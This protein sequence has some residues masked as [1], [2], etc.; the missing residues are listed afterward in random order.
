V[1]LSIGIGWLGVGPL[2]GNRDA[3]IGRLVSRKASEPAPT[4]PV[5]YR[6]LDRPYGGPTVESLERAAPPVDLHYRPTEEK[7]F[8]AALLITGFEPDGSLVGADAIAARLYDGRSCTGG[9]VEIDLG[10]DT[11]FRL[12]PLPVPTGH[13]VD[14]ASV[15]FDGVP[16]P[17][18]E[19]ESGQPAVQFERHRVGRVKY[20]T[21]PGA[22]DQRRVGSGWPELPTE[23]QRLAR[24]VEDLPRA[25]RALVV[26]DW[27]ARRVVYD[28]SSTTAARYREESTTSQGIF[29]RS[30]SIGAGDCDV[31][32]SLVAAT[33]DSSG[34]PARLAIGWMG[35][36]GRLQPD[37]HAWVEFLGEDGVWRVV[38]ASIRA[39]QE[40]RRQGGS[41]VSERPA[42]AS[43]ENWGWTPAI[44]AALLFLAGLAVLLGG[45]TWERR[46][47]VGPKND[48]PGLLR[49][50]ATRP[51]AFARIRPVFTR[52]VVPL[53]G[54]P[55][56]S[57]ARARKES[58]RGRLCRG[59]AGTRLAEQASTGG[60][61]VIDA[62]QAAG[63]AVADVLGAIDLDRW[64]EV[65]DSSWS[66]DVTA[67]VEAALG[68]GG[69]PCR[70]RVANGLG[71]ETMVL[72]G[73]LLG[74]GTDDCLAI[75]NAEGDL[76]RT[77]R[78]L[79]RQR[80]PARAVLWLADSMVHRIGVPYEALGRCLASL[81]AAAV[82][83]RAWRAS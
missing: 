73:G 33:L 35:A 58:L 8:I 44:V 56:T 13:R 80:E 11:E 55:P 52:R 7:P 77:V 78:S 62:E 26:A 42:P 4:A 32:N 60:G 18:V 22:S 63:R 24:E 40:D 30:L 75:V 45:R 83:E 29:H 76:W 51:G 48:L 46:L 50:A 39:D 16:I 82:K 49:G 72:D 54:R 57:L 28:T 20:R 1:V 27:V 5:P 79:T 68:A 3:S 38:D 43:R 74:L 61:L 21:G 2:S 25:L 41:P 6:G 64:Q 23:V 14:T 81:A 17:V 37:L 9:C 66:D 19:L 36:D 47:H 10:I 15:R 34:V 71:Q 70:L 53:L 67:E 65:L 59:S 69:Q 12:L 31:Q